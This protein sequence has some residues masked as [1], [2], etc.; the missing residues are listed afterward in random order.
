MRFLAVG[1]ALILIGL[2]INAIGTNWIDAIFPP[3]AMGQYVL[4][5]VTTN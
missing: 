2:L 3:A 4:L 1:V 5:S